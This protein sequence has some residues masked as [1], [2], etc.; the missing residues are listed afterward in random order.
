LG[1]PETVLRI[2]HTRHGFAGLD[3]M[4]YRRRQGGEHDPEGVAFEG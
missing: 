3:F 4:T 2:T 1:W